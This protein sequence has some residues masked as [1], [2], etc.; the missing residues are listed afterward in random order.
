ML[1]ERPSWNGKRRYG[2]IKNFLWNCGFYG[3]KRTGNIQLV[4][5]RQLKLQSPSTAWGFMSSNG[6]KSCTSVRA[7]LVS[8]D[9]WTDWSSMCCPPDCIFFKKLFILKRLYQTTSPIYS[10]QVSCNESIHI[11]I[12]SVFS[13]EDFFLNKYLFCCCRLLL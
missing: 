12:F 13:K 6:V 3:Q 5:N 1:I 2:M 9:I 8:H 10:P 4:I 7:A 11:F